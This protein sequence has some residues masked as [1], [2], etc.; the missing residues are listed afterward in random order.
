M[1]SFVK[2]NRREKTD[3]IYFYMHK[4]FWKDTHKKQIIVFRSEGN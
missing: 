2:K 3:I 1:L 4:I